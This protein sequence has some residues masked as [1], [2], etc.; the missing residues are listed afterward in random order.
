MKTIL[1]LLFT[2]TTYSQSF[3]ELRGGTT[4]REF[5]GQIGIGY[6]MES[7]NFRTSALYNSFSLDNAS[8]D[9]YDIEVGYSFGD[10]LI[11]LTPVIGYGYTNQRSWREKQDDHSPIYGVTIDFIFND[12]I[13]TFGYRD[14]QDINYTY[15]GI[16][17]R[18][19][20]SK[21]KSH[22]FF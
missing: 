21:N 16:K 7:N 11:K 19:R 5:G 20:L 22:R 14:N 1:L 17:I 18:F 9:R 4:I 8:V 13:A 10:K 2:V 6:S 15:G 3:V 12:L